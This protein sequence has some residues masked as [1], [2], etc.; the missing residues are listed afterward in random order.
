MTMLTGFS[1]PARRVIVQA[2]RLATDAGRDALGT[3]CLLW[4]LA[5]EPVLGGALH[6][7]GVTPDAVR[8]EITAGGARPGDRELLAALGIDL[9]EV[10]RRAS[11]ATAMDPDDPALWSLRRS[12]LRPLRVTLTGPAVRIRLDE[13]GRKA[14]EVAL[15]SGRRGR[16]AV[17]DPEDLLWGLLADGSNASVRILHRLE[18]DLRRL[19]SDLRHWQRAA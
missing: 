1:P 19:W 6:A 8:D 18:V 5:E 4:A 10:R 15:W 9:D 13:G 16:R 3:D 12:P 17:A 11:G 7:Q 2:G 14:V